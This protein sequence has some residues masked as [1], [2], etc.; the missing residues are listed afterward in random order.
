MKYLIGID[1]GTQGTKAALYSQEG[2]NIM[3]SFQSS[4][5]LYLEDGG[6]EQN[7]DEIY[8]SVIRSVQRLTSLSSINRED[9]AAIGMDGQMAGIMGIDADFNPV[10]N[11]D[12]WLDTRCEKYISK[13][14]ENENRVIE[15]TGASVSYFHGPKVLWRKQERPSEYKEIKKFIMITT[16]VAGK[17]VGLKTEDAFIDYT[18]LHFTGFA[19]TLHSCWSD[20]LLEYFDVDKQKMPQIVTPWKIIGHLTPKAAEDMGLSES[21]RVIAGCGDTAA[22]ILGAGVLSPGVAVDIAGT[23]SVFASCVDSFKPDSNHR[24]LLTAKSVIDGLWIQLA[25]IGGGGQC[26]AWFKNSVV[27]DVQLSF[28]QLCDETLELAPKSNGLMFIPHFAG[29]TCPNNPNIRGSW[30][31]L[32]WSHKRGNLFLSIMESIAYEYHH[33]SDISKIL[34]GKAYLKRIL[35]VGGGAKS[36]VFNQIKADVLQTEYIPMERKDSATL[37][38]AVIAGYG[39]GLFD[40]IENAIGAFVKPGVPVQPN[41]NNKAIYEDAAGNYI[42]IMKLL[43]TIYG[44][45][46]EK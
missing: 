30:L 1:I 28:E 18:H 10:G 40:S 17:M 39:I 46:A 31:N 4:N 36:P 13:M 24:T 14:K 26:L 16:Y 32:N 34:L 37:A 27:Q 2:E 5:L 44:N 12:S 8:E 38:C 9:I 45:K 19:D 35:G 22:T 6:I 3:E 23:A 29:R 11:Y 21:T 20:E 41:I 42:N 25:Y 43:E 15:L 7:P 33:Y